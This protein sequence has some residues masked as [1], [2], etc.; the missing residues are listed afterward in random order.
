MRVQNLAAPDLNWEERLSAV[1]EM[2]REMSK[3]TDPQLM[4]QQYAARM[5]RFRRVDRSISLSRRDIEPPRV[6]ITRSTAWEDSVNPWKEPEKLPI[7]NGGILSELIYGDEPRII[8]DFS[9]SPDDP[10]APY[11]DGFSS[12]V[13][14]PLLDQGVALN[15]VVHLRRES[16]TFD[17]E[18]LPEHVWTANLFGRATNSLVLADK[19]KTKTMQRRNVGRFQQRQL[20]RQPQGRCRR[21]F[22]SR[23]QPQPHFRRR[24]LRERHH[25]NLIHTPVILLLQQPRQAAIH[26]RASFARPGP[27]HDQH[28][29]AGGDGLPLLLCGRRGIQ[30][31]KS[32]RQRAVEV[33][34]KKRPRGMFGAFAGLL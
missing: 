4:V 23:P 19:V 10:A 33:N 28:I 6:K 3:Q 26:Q 30:S 1:M 18:L 22:Q 24:R 34:M 13:A 12:L 15:M 14:I 25:E 20:F 29:A 27:G 5:K 32:I 2:M 31:P 11:L 17:P 16:G 9:V 8:E 7:L 21:V